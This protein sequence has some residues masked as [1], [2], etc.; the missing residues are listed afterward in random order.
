MAG[1]DSPPANSKGWKLESSA[2]EI[3]V[4]ETASPSEQFA[5]EELQAYFKK[6]SGAEIPIAR[7][8]AVKGRKAILVGRHASSRP[9]WE[10]L[11]NPDRHIIDVSPEVI[12]IVGGFK[13][14]VTNS[15]GTEFVFDWGVLYGVYQLL[16]DQGI[17]WFRPE[18]DGEHVP[19]AKD[20]RVTNGR[21][22]YEPAFALRW[23]AS[24]YASKFLKTATKEESHLAGLWALR[25]RANPTGLTDPKYGGHLNIGGGG[26][27]YSSLVPPALFATHPDFFPLID[28]VRKAKGQICQ[29]NPAV[30][31]LFADKII[32][33][34]KQNPQLFMTSID[35]NDGG[36]WCECE[37]C[38]AMDDP[39]VVSGRGGGLSMSSRVTAFNNIVARIV[40]EQ[41]PNLLLYCLAYSQ[42][43][44]APTRVAR[45]EPNLVIGLAPFAGAFSDYS[46]ALRDP[47]STP[48]KRFLASMEGYQKLGAKMYAREYLSH[49]AWPG[50][51]P[52]LRTMQDR[53]QE[54]K[55]AGF[56]GV[57]SESH[58]C[59]GPQGLILYMYFRLLNDPDLDMKS[60]LTNYCRDF[61]GPAAIPM[62][63]Y[64]EALERVAK[65]GPYFGSGGSHAQNLFTDG[66][67]AELKAYVEDATSAAKGKKLYEW[68]VECVVAGYELARLYRQT[69]NFI[70]AG[71]FKEAKSSMNDLE[72]FYG[73]KYPN[74]DVFNKGE[75]TYK[76]A[77][78]E[79]RVIAFIRDLGMEIAK[80]ETIESRFENART[81]QILDSAWKFQT[82]PKEIGVDE[83]WHLT[84]ANDGGWARINSGQPWQHQGFADFSGTAWYRR[85]FPT[86]S[87]EGK[88]RLIL[89]FQAVDG[90]VTVWV[91]GKEAGRRD[92]LD[93][94]GVNHW[95]DPFTFDITDHIA[96]DTL[97]TLSV[98]VK[99][100]SGNGGI[101]R[102]VKLLRVD[103]NEN[104]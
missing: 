49:Y 31:R 10:N 8:G 41:C 100:T 40:A 23:G 86:P 20:L 69:A 65:D 87:L 76:N 38:R 64:H 5:A 32:S 101:H 25:N 37:L 44:E 82:D 29:G 45:L 66:V 88:Q 12:R 96:P 35:P 46:R 77:N 83:G 36:G 94:N 48:N 52:L 42:Y 84:A 13:P 27:V 21:K 74:G 80:N 4:P 104:R 81:V 6:M 68:R 55:K 58:P 67:L 92:L 93:L 30:Q 18:P 50:P 34:G 78:G 95:D 51:L 91:N 90:D 103:G 71:N 62:L 59:W 98:R 28:G 72:Q 3:R 39:R 22:D 75:A 53:F 17:R 89:V 24:L 26:H 9:L 97:N 11:D 85:S 47:E 33:E 19:K 14:P 7:G 54:Y 99:K 70:K 56:I 16:E 2:F 79:P 60:E 57:Y 43:M 61:Y 1:C 63:K 73:G 102:S 15:R